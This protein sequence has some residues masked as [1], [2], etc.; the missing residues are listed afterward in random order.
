MS[1]GEESAGVLVWRRGPQ[2]L[3]VLLVHPGGPWWSNKDA[4]A[5]TIPKGAI[6]AGEEP[7]EAA[8]RELREE[9]GLELD[10]PFM[11]LEAVRQKAGKLV[12]AFAAQGDCDASACTSNTFT[13][14]WPPRSGRIREYPEVDRAQWFAIAEARGRINPAQ[15]ALLEQLQAALG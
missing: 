8:R 4:G 14:E 7:L 12:I 6:D 10:G 9:T 3:E 5:W 11:P 1:K 13:L 2:G 15:V